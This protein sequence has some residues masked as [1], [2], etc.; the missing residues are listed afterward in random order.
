MGS[1]LEGKKLQYAVIGS[2]SWATALV[3]LLSTTQDKLYWFVRDDRNIDFI[4]QYGRNRSYLR[5]AVLNLDKIVMSDDI[6]E[7]VEAADVLVFCIPSSYFLS[8]IKALSTSLD[9]KYIVS[10]IK[11][12]VSK[13][14][15]TIAEFFHNLYHIPF[16]N[17]A[18]VSGPTHAEEV[19][20]EK[21]SYITISSKYHKVAEQI[22][23]A[24]KCHYV[25]V[26][27]GTDIYGVEY[28]A[29]MKNVYAV[30]VGLCHTLGYGDN[31]ISVLVT[32]AYREMIHFI[33]QSHPDRDRIPTRSAYLGDLLVTCYSQFS[34]NRTFGGMI[35][36]GYSVVSA[37]TE[38]NMVAE[39]YYATKSIYEIAKRENIELPI[40]NAMYGILYEEK[41]PE[42]TL[43]QL[44]DMLQ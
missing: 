39:G 37:H 30:A 24:F 12:F 20:M 4:K 8:Q 1:F 5:S 26:I 7:V 17:I 35:G 13:D 43:R 25:K 9:D 14:N 42:Y 6:N 19:A 11:G 29:A 22:S 44:M 10:A 28:S 18:I 16:E 34:R 23:E 40:V 32:G 41:N 36:K 33:Q 2:G 3:K 38:M 21:Y 15:L 31:F 27:I